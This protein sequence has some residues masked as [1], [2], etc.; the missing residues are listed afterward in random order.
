MKNRSFPGQ[1]GGNNVQD[2]LWN[3][4]LLLKGPHDFSINIPTPVSLGESET[5]PGCTRDP[6]KADPN[7]PQWSP[8]H[9]HNLCGLSPPFLIPL[10]NSHCASEN[11]SLSLCP[12]KYLHSNSWPKL[13]HSSFLQIMNI[14]QAFQCARCCDTQMTSPLRASVFSS[15]K[16]GQ[17]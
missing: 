13:R 8:A 5:S 7:H 4:Q 9:C 17:K 6:S 11:C 3:S 1:T 10:L 16:W 15:M 14:H 2:T 12:Y